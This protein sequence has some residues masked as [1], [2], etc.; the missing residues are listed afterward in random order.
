M[1]KAK[2]DARDWELLSKYGPSPYGIQGTY[3]K[4]N[5]K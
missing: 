2:P 4:S 5:Y 1:H 3:L